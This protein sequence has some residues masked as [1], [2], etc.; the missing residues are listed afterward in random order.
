MIAQLEKAIHMLE[1]SE[2]Y[3]YASALKRFYGQILA[4]KS[5]EDI[6][7]DNEKWL[8]IQGVKNPPR[9]CYALF[10]IDYSKN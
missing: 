6:F 7:A 10:P 9:F 8:G 4:S 1:Q 3:V 2:C 5:G